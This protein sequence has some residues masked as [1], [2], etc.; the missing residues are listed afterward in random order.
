MAADV[1]VKVLTPRGPGGVAVVALRGPAAA[2]RAEALVRT[3]RGA[4]VRVTAVPRLCWLW[5]DGGPVDQVLVVRRADGAVE[6]HLHGA[7]AVLAALERAVG[8][9]T[10]APVANPA[11][12]LLE[13][14]GSEGQLALALEQLGGPGG[15]DFAAFVG[16][17]GALPPGA[18]RAAARAARQRGRLAR[19]LA[20]PARLVLCGAQNAGKSTLMNRLL[21]TQRVLAGGVAG[22]TRDV[23]GEITALG[24][25]PYELIDA[26]GYG[27]PASAVDR[28]A[29]DRAQ[30]AARGAWRLLLIEAARAPEAQDLA[31]INARTIVV[32]SK[33]DQP[34]AAWPTAGPAPELRLSA[35]DPAASAS[36]RAAVGECLRRRRCL[37]VAP[38]PVGG[39]APLDR[40]QRLGLL[41]VTRRAPGGQ[42][43]AAEE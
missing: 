40:A 24:G 10:A 20:E 14:A 25:Y 17:I 21:G 28:A 38:G 6:L 27:A 42:P 11:Q 31:W 29:Q 36:L 5:L 19:V 23:V 3:A 1:E 43:R 7:E 33:A 4:P 18:R 26:A 8:G 12:R 41:A 32:Q 16:E 9:W 2:G 22:L 37:P 15:R 34:A 35:A 39:L 30:R 13:Q